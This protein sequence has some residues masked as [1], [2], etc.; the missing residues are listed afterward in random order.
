ML[1]NIDDQFLVRWR[2]FIRMALWWFSDTLNWV[3]IL[4]CGNMWI[5]LS[6]SFWPRVGFIRVLLF[7]ELCLSALEF[8]I[9]SLPSSHGSTGLRA[10]VSRGTLDKSRNW[11]HK[12]I[13]FMY[14]HGAL[15]LWDTKTFSQETDQITIVCSDHLFPIIFVNVFALVVQTSFHWQRNFRWIEIFSEFTLKIIP[16]GGPE[17]I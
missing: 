10:P 15:P 12:G 14:L 1:M 8:D 11:L 17:K 6:V 7:L 4:P 5:E 9:S 13:Y 16:H 3:K 2:Y